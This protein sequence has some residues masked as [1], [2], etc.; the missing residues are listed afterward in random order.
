MGIKSVF[1][2]PNHHIEKDIC[3]FSQERL[4]AIMQVRI[5]KSTI[6]ANLRSSFFCVII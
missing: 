6:I 3:A 5:R 4:E 2:I 1:L